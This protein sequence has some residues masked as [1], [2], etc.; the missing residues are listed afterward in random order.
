MG[1][2]L[3][4]PKTDKFSQD[5][6][7]ENVRYGLS[8][9]QGWRTSMEDAHAAYPDLDCS[10]S[11]FGVYDGHG[12]QAVSKF[13]AKYLHQQVIKHEAYSSGDIGTAVQKSFIRMDEMMRGQRG[14]IELAI[15]GDKT[16]KLS[17]MKERLIGSRESSEVKSQDDDWS[18]E[19]GPHSNYEGPTCGSTACVAVIRNNQLIVANS[20][21]SRCVISRKGQAYNLSKDHKPDLESEKE[22][23][24]KA[25]GFIHCGRV[26]G[27]LNLTRAIGDME[28]K[29]DKSL[30]AE[31]QIL[32]ANPD[33]NTVELCEDD[34]FLVIAC[35]GIWDCMSNQQL[36]DFVREQLKT[37][38][39][40]STIC[41]KVFD[42]CLAPT[43]GGEGCDNM[44]MILVQFKKRP[45]PSPSTS[46][47]QTS[48]DESSETSDSKDKPGSN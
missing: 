35:D 34:D 24:S 33:I 31:K 47:Q 14:W 7:N 2:Y 6:E 39:K 25:G 16:E 42:R 11:F 9:M 20:G 44:T 29:K 43:S 13:C 5:G 12:G 18:V 37:E 46:E 4:T 41:G 1:V 19:E 48:I 28:L 3:S 40:L 17:G 27:T 22:R 10:T 38:S 21:D 15:L 26:N 36:V 8:S 30:P 32:T 45:D 23:I